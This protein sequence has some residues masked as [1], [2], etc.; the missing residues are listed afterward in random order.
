M[1]KFFEMVNM[2]PYLLFL[3]LNIREGVPDRR[4]TGH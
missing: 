1:G 3:L 4:G 2:P